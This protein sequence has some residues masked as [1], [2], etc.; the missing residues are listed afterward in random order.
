MKVI[1]HLI[2]SIRLA[3][4]H[5]SEAEERPH[6]ILWTD[7]DRQWENVMSR[8]KLE[9]PELLILGEYNS[10]ERTGPAIWIRTAIAGYVDGYSIP[11]G[12]V[13]IIYL[14]GVSRQDLRAVDQCPEELK[15]LA[16]LQYR[17]IIWSQINS[18]D[19]T[20]F[21]YMKTRRGGLGLDIAKDEATI[22]AMNRALIKV[23]DERIE[24]LSN[25]HLDKQFFNELI[26]GTDIVKDIL[27]WIS[28]PENF[29]AGRTNQQWQAFIEICN[30][31]YKFNP[32]L[33]GI[34]TA[35]ERIAWKDEDWENVWERFCEAPRKYEAIPTLL[36]N[37]IHPLLETQERNPN[38]NS[39]QEIILR[40][41][42]LNLSDV[43]EHKARE[44]IL[45][46]E[47]VHCNR[48]EQV[49][50]ELGE[51]PL[52]KSLKWLCEM[53]TKTVNNIYGNLQEIALIQDSW[54]WKID[55]A[56][57]MAL[58]SLER[59]ED[60]DAVSAAVRSIYLP[61]IDTNARILQ[62]LAV[63]SGYPNESSVLT[64]KDHECVLFIDGLR[65]D[66]AKRLAEMCKEKG[67]VINENVN[68][69]PLP[70]VTSTCKP[71][72][73]P[74]AEELV[75]DLTNNFDFT[76]IF[77][78]EGKSATYQKLS[79]R[80]GQKGWKILSNTDL[81]NNSS[82]G[83]YEFGRVDSE[84]HSIGWRIS[85]NAEDYL[86]EILNTIES[87][88]KEGWKSIKIVSDHGWLM[89]PK[90]L[91]KVNLSSSLTDSKWGR[92][93]AIKPGALYD[94][95]SFPWYWNPEVHF[96]LAEGVGCYRNG[97]EYSHGGLSVQESLML[98]I[99]VNVGDN[100]KLDLN[101]NLT[102]LVWKGM[103]CKVAVEGNYH[104]VKLDI[105]LKPALSE[106]SIVMGVKEFNENG[107]TSVVVDDDSNE[108][109]KAFLVLL[110]HSNTI[111]LQRET[112]VGG[113]N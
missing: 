73:M 8:L 4:R 24:N 77:R 57:L 72:L 101:I 43:P 60:I 34:F 55:Y 63:E 49:W 15:P 91:P 69:A 96:A 2:N 104:G 109:V 14:P 41:E 56:V 26:S 90:G 27:V 61:W 19:W 1:T 85:Q 37:V 93:A 5:N 40:A 113:E 3:S 92:S 10:T 6:C 11:T 112:V 66:L 86:N 39:E 84:G 100:P 51:A 97:V 42:L 64:F 17:G 29:K 30:T 52:A 35:I 74:V 108:G 103:R 81:K 71:A 23:L 13:P 75:G 89:V 50:A 88:V 53:A 111:L 59:Q 87:L 65:F 99:N 106:T 22:Y 46:L 16:E 94:G 25:I 44:E 47:K 78:D 110:D 98:Q 76:P 48:R 105:R 20:V 33:D 36:K 67:L 31:K 21:A 7:K 83:W 12:L 58:S 70:T 102:D 9:M 82:H 62:K 18:R 80:M 79:T 45:Q 28:S 95:I 54:G 38:W 68:W 107:I 32:E